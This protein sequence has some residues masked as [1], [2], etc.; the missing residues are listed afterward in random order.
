[1]RQTWMAASAVL[2]LTACDSCPEG[3]ERRRWEAIECDE[4]TRSCEMREVEGCACV[5]ADCNCQ[6]SEDCNGC[7]GGLSGADEWVQQTPSENLHVVDGAFTG[8]EWEDTTRLEGLFTDVYMDYRDGRLYFLNDW[9]ANGEGI[10][11][12]C[13]NYFQIQLGDSFL[14]LRVYGSG[15]VEVTRDGVP[16]PHRAEG[17]YGFGPSPENAEPHTIYEF[18]LE[19]EATQIDVCC[20]DPLTESS[21]EDLAHE[22]VVVSLRVRGGAPEVRRAVPAGSVTRL[23]RGEA[24]GDGQGVCEDGLHCERDGERRV[25]LGPGPVPEPDAGPRPDSGPPE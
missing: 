22:P 7:A 13:F 18:S 17:A 9:R 11:P 10:R 19:I 14:D 15:E 2:A 8:A 5:S 16:Q 12:T 25:C 6:A 24:C 3:H 21:C 4:A 20:F 23:G 1:M